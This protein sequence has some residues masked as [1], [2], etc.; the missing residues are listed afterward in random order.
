M[1]TLEKCRKQEPRASF[2]SGYTSRVF[3]NGRSVLLQRTTR[4]RLLHL[5]YDIE[6]LGRKTIEH[7]FCKFYALKLKHG[8]LTNKSAR[9]VLSML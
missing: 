1:R 8:F 7:A 2:F 9:R 5:L 4:L 6:I 3:S